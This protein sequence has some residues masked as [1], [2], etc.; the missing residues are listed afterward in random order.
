L[1]DY[2]VENGDFWD[3]QRRAEGVSDMPCAPWTQKQAERFVLEAGWMPSG[4][5]VNGAFL[6]GPESLEVLG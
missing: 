5:V 1:I 4:I 2:L 3:Q 6:S